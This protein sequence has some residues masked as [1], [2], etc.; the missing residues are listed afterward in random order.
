VEYFCT[1]GDELWSTPDGDVER[2]TVEGL[3]RLGFVAPEDVDGCRVLR[4]AKA[5]PLFEVGFEKDAEGLM[6][7]LSG[8]ENF[9]PAGRS[10]V[11]QYYNMDHAIRSGLEAAAKVLNGPGRS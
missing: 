11:F 3:N 4:V 8:L 6:Q 7:W 2:M 9:H 1:A 5:Y 10:G